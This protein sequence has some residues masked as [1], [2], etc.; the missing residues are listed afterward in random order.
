LAKERSLISVPKRAWSR[1]ARL[2]PVTTLLLA[3]AFSACSALPPEPVAYIAPDLRFSLPSPRELGRS[4]NAV[5]LVTAHYRGDVQMFEAHLSVSPER[6]TLIGL[7]PFGRRALTVT[8]TDAGMT[9]DKASWLPQGLRPEN[10]LADLAI[11]YWPEDAV[12]R[13]LARTDAVLTSDARERSIS[14]GGREVVRVDYGR[15]TGDAWT[16][17]AHYRNAVFGYEL[18]LRSAVETP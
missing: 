7:D 14:A 4:V 17:V 18:D 2:R 11:V 13:G 15:R 5:Q 12:R 9:V 16:G 10:I 3:M 1:I 6:L 8:M